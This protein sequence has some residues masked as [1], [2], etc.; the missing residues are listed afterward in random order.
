MLLRGQMNR[1]S[2]K[3]NYASLGDVTST[4]INQLIPNYIPV[5]A[6]R[7]AYDPNMVALRRT[8]LAAN[9][10]FIP[11]TLASQLE[12]KVA[13]CMSMQKSELPI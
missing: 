4:I 9:R 11:S 7:E 12:E 6:E 13:S 8:G 1:P 2:N 5:P 3:F 10:S